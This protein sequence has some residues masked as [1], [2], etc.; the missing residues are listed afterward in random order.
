MPA[1][2]LTPEKKDP[3]IGQGQLPLMLLDVGNLL[4]SDT[5]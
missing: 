3:N 1:T 4:E 2:K 5:V